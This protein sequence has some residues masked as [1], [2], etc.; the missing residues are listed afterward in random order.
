L[1]AGLPGVTYLQ[2]RRTGALGNHAVW[3]QVDGELP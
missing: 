3:V 1:R 2:V